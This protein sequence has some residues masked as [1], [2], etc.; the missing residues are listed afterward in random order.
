MS[1]LCDGA[2]ECLVLGKRLAGMWESGSVHTCL[3][4]Q[5]KPDGPVTGRHVPGFG[6]SVFLV[7]QEASHGLADAPISRCV[8][9]S[10]LTAW[11]TQ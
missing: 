6:G 11:L 1:P 7:E 8:L 5:T 4:G 9:H 10:V 3:W 2:A